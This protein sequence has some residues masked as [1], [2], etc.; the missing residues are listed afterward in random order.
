MILLLPRVFAVPVPPR[1]SGGSAV[2]SRQ[3]E[4]IKPTDITVMLAPKDLSM[5][6]VGRSLT[7]ILKVSEES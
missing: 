4:Y 7:V 3:T 6:L 2:V 5:F 1:K